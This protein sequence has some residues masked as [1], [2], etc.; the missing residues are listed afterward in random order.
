MKNILFTI[1]FLVSNCKNQVEQVD[2]A[3]ISNTSPIDSV[4]TSK[5]D[6]SKFYTTQDTIFII[7][8]INDT[9]KFGKQEFNKIIDDHP[10][11]HSSEYAEEP[12]LIYHSKKDNADFDS[13]VGAEVYYILYAHFLKQKNGVEKYAIQRKKLIEIFKNINSLFASFQYG[14]TYFGHQ[15]SKIPAY[16]EYGVYQYVDIGEPEKTYNIKKQKTYYI[17]SLRQLIEDENEIDNET[18]DK[19][20]K[21]KRI[22]KQHKIVDEIDKLITDNFYLRQAQAFHYS[23]YQYY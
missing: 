15:Q 21:A 4:S 22:K 20:E 19:K 23:K 3:T 10:E 17:T 8:E 11:L 6:Y 13:E 1:L 5:V 7:S 18:I 12:D 2:K 14:G 9:L 16:S